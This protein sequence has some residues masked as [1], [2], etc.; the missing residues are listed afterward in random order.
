MFLLF[1][2]SLFL[3]KHFLDYVCDTSFKGVFRQ[4]SLRIL[5]RR[6]SVA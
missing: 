1:W 2:N 5:L 3:G 6:C 4:F